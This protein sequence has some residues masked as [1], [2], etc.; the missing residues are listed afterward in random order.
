MAREAGLSKSIKY[1]TDHKPLHNEDK[2]MRTVVIGY[3]NRYIFK[4]HT[5]VA[6]KLTPTHS[7]MD[8]ARDKTKNLDTMKRKNTTN[9]AQPNLV[10]ERGS[11]E[12]LMPEPLHPLQ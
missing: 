1:C 10:I 11:M 4:Y 9:A 5:K 2:L 8:R 12:D 7:R 3:Y 6:S